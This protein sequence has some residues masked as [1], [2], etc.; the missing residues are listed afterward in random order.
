MLGRKQK[1]EREGSGISI[2]GETFW[3][4]FPLRHL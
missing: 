4:S 1:P 2:V 3:K